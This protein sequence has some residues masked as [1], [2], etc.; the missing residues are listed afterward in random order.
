VTKEQGERVAIAVFAG[1]VFRY[2]VVSVAHLDGFEIRAEHPK[3]SYFG[4]VCFEDRT[5]Q[6]ECY[7]EAKCLRSQME[8]AILSGDVP[9]RKKVPLAVE[10]SQ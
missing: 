10:V 4:V 9:F 5:D 7:E 1:S 2:R 8:Q 3:F 6:L